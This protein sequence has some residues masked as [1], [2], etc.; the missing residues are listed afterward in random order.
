MSERCP[1]CEFSYAW[2][3]QRCNHC[4]FVSV[5]RTVRVGATTGAA[6]LSLSNAAQAAAAPAA[7]AASAAPLAA[8]PAVV[9]PVD[10]AA[11]GS[12]AGA[13]SGS[14]IMDAIGEFLAE[15]LNALLG[16]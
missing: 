12:I 14:E 1:K 13:D 2:D 6:V 5:T 8:T 9:L 16:G 15:V 4:K 10:T 3:G 7:V 11:S